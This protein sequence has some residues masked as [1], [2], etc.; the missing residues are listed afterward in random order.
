MCAQG[1][2]PLN[3]IPGYRRIL[4]GLRLLIAHRVID[5]DCLGEETT[6]ISKSFFPFNQFP[7]LFKK[8]FLAFKGVDQ[9]SAFS[10]QCPNCVC[11]ATFVG[12]HDHC[13]FLS[14]FCHSNPALRLRA[15]WGI[16]RSMKENI[17]AC[18]SESHTNFQGSQDD[19][20]E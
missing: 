12:F 6:S 1:T 18:E 8:P 15:Y 4:L 5:V 19:D 17:G 9:G 11:S 3:K 13:T 10:I 14:L 20:T 2:A 7:V 16:P